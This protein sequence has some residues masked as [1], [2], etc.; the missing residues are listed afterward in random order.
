MVTQKDIAREL[1]LAVITVSKALSG[2]SDIRKA[3][4][5]R[6]VEKARKMG[7]RPNYYSR[8]LRGG[9]MGTIGF[10]MPE[11]DPHDK[12]S[13]YLVFEYIAGINDYTISRNQLLS[14]VK[15]PY[16]TAGDDTPLPP[17]LAERCVDG[18]I[19][20]MSLPE[21]VKPIL[22]EQDIPVV[23]LDADMRDK[24]N[25]VYRDEEDAGYVATSYLIRHGHSD[26][27]MTLPADMGKPHPSCELIKNGYCRAMAEADLPERYLIFEKPS[28][29]I[30]RMFREMLKR[31]D[32][33]AACVGIGMS[34]L[35]FVAVRMGLSVPKDLSLVAA[36]TNRAERGLFL[37]LTH[38]TINRYEMAYAAGEMLEKLIDT[39]KPQPSRVYM[40]EIVEG[41]TVAGADGR[42]NPPSY[43][44]CLGGE[45]IRD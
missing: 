30:D 12:T 34:R 23:W 39:G 26:I 25:C 17:L 38:V 27:L 18:L 11:S 6:V 5:E 40:G 16:C 13:T 35:Y 41:L 15:L 8:M 7:Y 3:T 20:Y 19:A 33:P 31:P 29:C 22:E 2:A 44:D 32:R 42:E 28:S 4:R 10:L 43:D 21:R 9:R 36:G 24:T 37:D 1:D 14:L 45:S